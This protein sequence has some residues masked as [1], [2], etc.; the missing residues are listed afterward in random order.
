MKSISTL[1]LFIV[2]LS[3]SYQ[4]KAQFIAAGHHRSYF[5]CDNSLKGCGFNYHGQLG[6][7]NEINQ[8][9]GPIDIL[10]VSDIKSIAVGINHTLFLTNNN[11]VWA[12]GYNAF[13]QLGNGTSGNS[14]SIPIQIP[15]FDNVKAIAAGWDFSLFL[16]NDSTVW[17][18]G[19]NGFGALGDSTIV[20]NQNTPR[21]INLD[22]IVA[23][24]AGS[25]FSLFLKS[26][27]TVW[28]SGNNEYGQIGGDAYNHWTLKQIEG[29]TDIMAIAGGDGHSLFLKSDSTVWGLGF[30][31]GAL[32]DGTIIERQS[33]VQ[34]LGLDHIVAIDAGWITSFFLKDD[35]TVWSC[36]VNNF[37]ALGDG[38]VIDRNLPVQVNNVS[39]ITNIAVGWNHTLFLKDDN[40][41]WVCGW[42][43]GL[44]PQENSAVIV[45]ENCTAAASVPEIMGSGHQSNLFV[46]NPTNGTIQLKTDTQNK[47]M[48]VE[49][50]DESGRIIKQINKFENQ[51]EIDLSSFSNGLY[52]LYIS[53]ETKIEVQ[54][55]YLLR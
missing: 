4:L 21:Q 46:P 7:G 47:I 22:S 50:T 45:N 9:Q 40:S 39:A 23:I 36:G 35:G 52:T 54:K 15:S 3:I 37:G 49:I 12:C 24:S 2:L 51:D 10:A 38:T 25:W 13:G 1:F 43:S 31:G 19:Q 18:C 28:A 34:V 27:G 6:N 30:N 8:N 5:Y 32:G 14:S 16:K 53:Y 33:P 48:T 17:V 44:A 55:I 29:L 42:N 20:N 11:T 41:V 26:D